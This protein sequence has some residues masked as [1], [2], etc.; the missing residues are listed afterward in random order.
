M[1]RPRNKY[2]LSGE[3]G[4]ALSSWPVW[5]AFCDLIIKQTAGGAFV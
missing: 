1:T 2:R 3:F 5:P 4:L